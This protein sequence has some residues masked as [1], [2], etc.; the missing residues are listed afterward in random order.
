[1]EKRVFSAFIV[2][3]KSGL[4]WKRPLV[5]GMCFLAAIFMLAGC[6]ADPVDPGLD[7]PG[8]KDFYPV[9]V[10]ANK[11][12]VGTVSEQCDSTGGVV[13]KIR[14]DPRSVPDS[15]KKYQ[16]KPIVMSL[17]SVRQQQIF[18]DTLTV[19]EN[20]VCHDEEASI[21]ILR[22]WDPFYRNVSTILATRELPGDSTVKRLLLL[23][24]GDSVGTEGCN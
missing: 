20:S 14:F 4:R 11:W 17:D 13:L 18:R 7:D 21:E 22:G 16:F 5:F 6:Q 19:C 12:W 23:R 8:C 3:P 1:V 10:C 24:L 2:R 9:E 15:I